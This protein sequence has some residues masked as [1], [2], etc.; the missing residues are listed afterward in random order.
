VQ[1]QQVWEAFPLLPCHPACLLPPSCFLEGEQQVQ[2]GGGDFSACRPLLLRQRRVCVCVVVVVVRQGPK[3]GR[4][5]EVAAELRVCGESPGGSLVCHM[6][7]NCRCSSILPH[8]QCQAPANQPSF[9]S[10][11]PPSPPMPPP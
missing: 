8:Q 3:G 1:G 5:A 10:P 9:L 11:P 4:K 7:Q 6:A 2:Q